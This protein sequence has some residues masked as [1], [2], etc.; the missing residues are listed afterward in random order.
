VKEAPVHSRP[1]HAGEGVVPSGTVAHVPTL[2]GRLHRSHAALQGPPQQTP[3]TQKPEAH[4]LAAVQ[5][6]P[7]SF[8]GPQLPPSQ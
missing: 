5:E 4:W 2:P 7:A 8:F 1:P 3:S 6:R